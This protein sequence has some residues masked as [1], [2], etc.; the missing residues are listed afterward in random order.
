MGDLYTGTIS[1]S[2]TSFIIESNMKVKIT[3]KE[4]D[5]HPIYERLKTIEEVV[6]VTI[7]YQP[8]KEKMTLQ[9]VLDY[10]YHFIDFN[11]I[12]NNR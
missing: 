8:K 11:L 6:K 3:S 7:I 12:L 4:F 9:F 5:F 2:K 10:Y 1:T